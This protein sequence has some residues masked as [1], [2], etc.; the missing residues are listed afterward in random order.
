MV[1]FDTSLVIQAYDGVLSIAP[2]GTGVPDA[3]D[4]PLPGGYKEAGWLTE[5]GLTLTP[6]VD[7]PDPIKG[8]PRGEILKRPVPTL[9][10][11]LKF[12]CAQHDPDVLTMLTKTGVQMSYVVDYRDT[13]TSSTHRLIV[14]KGMVIDAGDIP[15][16]VTD[17]VNVEFTVGASRDD[18]AGYTIC[19]LVPDPANP[20]ATLSF[21]Y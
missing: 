10:P 21:P 7:A 13:V 17:L 16:N 20:T 2:Y 14:P 19:F 18:T 12:A 4:T 1:A 15:F 9:V 8:W 5:D 3:W 6:G 11:E